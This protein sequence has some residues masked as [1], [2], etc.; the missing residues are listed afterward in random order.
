MIFTSESTLFVSVQAPSG[1]LFSVPAVLLRLEV[2][3]LPAQ[4]EDALVHYGR[5]HAQR[6]GAHDLWGE[7]PQH[8]LP[9]ALLPY[10][11]PE[12]REESGRGVLSVLRL[13]PGFHDVQRVCDTRTR[14]AC[15][16]ARSHVGQRLPHSNQGV[17]GSLAQSVCGQR[18]LEVGVGLGGG[19]AQGNGS[20]WHLA[21]GAGSRR[22]EEA[23]GEEHL[24]VLVLQGAG[25]MGVFGGHTNEQGCTAV[26]P[27][28]ARRTVHHHT[29]LAT[30]DVTTVAWKPL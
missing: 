13:D 27:I 3:V 19:T 23:C 8:G 7:T 9:E 22:G 20:A 11:V 14:R 6:R 4:E 30:A 12:A 2:A 21:L 17:G 1:T 18:S 26:T 10:N 28:A 29:P 24:E 25:V 16:E 5:D 15:K